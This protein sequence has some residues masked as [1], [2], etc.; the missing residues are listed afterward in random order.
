MWRPLG[1]GYRVEARIE[2]WRDSA[3][4]TVPVSALFRTDSAWSVFVVENGVARRRAVEIGRRNAVAAQIISGIEEGETVV[5]HPG[6][7]VD[8]GV[9]VVDRATLID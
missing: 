8:D 4:L 6:D 1:H 9:T 7:R 3:A 2:L 5:V